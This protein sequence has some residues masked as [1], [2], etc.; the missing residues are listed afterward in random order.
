MDGTPI[1]LNGGFVVTVEPRKGGGSVV[2]PIGDGLDYDVRETPDVVLGMLDGVPPAPIA[3]PTPRSLTPT[4][5]DVSPETDGFLQGGMEPP[6][7]ESE[8]KASEPKTAQRPAKRGSR[9]T[10]KSAPAPAP[11]S[12]PVASAAAPAQIQGMS[13][14]EPANAFAPVPDAGEVSVPDFAPESAAAPA[15][16]PVESADFGG[17]PDIFA[18]PDLSVEQVERLRRMAPGSLRKLRN[19]LVSQLK[20]TDVERT[21]L[22]LQNQGVITLERDRVIW[23]PVT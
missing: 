19:T 16:A 5:A 20:V 1:W 15:P 22:S 13:V 6:S 8:P 12:E 2:V 21:V 7:K 3:V 23:N 10:A 14:A 17:A 11:E 4:P 9:K 18:A